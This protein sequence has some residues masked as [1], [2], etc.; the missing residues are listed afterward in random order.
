MTYRE[1]L[2]FMQ[3]ELM[4]VLD[5]SER[6]AIIDRTLEHISSKSKWQLMMDSDLHFKKEELMKVVE[7]LKQEKP[8]QYIL[9]FEYFGD[10]ILKVNEAVLIPRTETQELCDWVLQEVK[11]DRTIKNVLDIGTGSGCIPVYLK[12][13]AP[14]M[15]MEAWD[16]SSKALEIARSNAQQHEADISF[17][18]KN[19][20]DS[21]D[22]R[23]GDWDLIISNPP[24]ITEDEKTQMQSR[25]LHHE[26]HEALFVTNGDA[27]QF[28]KAILEY[29]EKNLKPDGKIFLEVHQDYAKATEQLFIQAGRQTELRKDMYG[30][31]R[32]LKANK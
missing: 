23:N 32:M 13:H 26:P 31:D 6:K 4:N 18:E 15:K 28:Y 7:E 24:Y 8:I 12:H 25:V 10:L 14:L 22:E 21:L 9:G 27:L 30:N 5:D 19:L 29:A 2:L 20:F 17:L 16:I 3:Q 11:K 1:A